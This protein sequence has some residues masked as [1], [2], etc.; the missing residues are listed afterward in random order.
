MLSEDKLAALETSIDNWAAEEKIPQT[1]IDLVYEMAQENPKT[2]EDKAKCCQK[3]FWSTELIE[4]YDRFIAYLIKRKQG[5]SEE[6]AT[7]TD[8]KKD[9]QT[10]IA[11]LQ[12]VLAVVEKHG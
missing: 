9:L 8:I 12:R 11:L 3:H 1:V 6:T 7:S 4:W 2:P 10:A 5:N